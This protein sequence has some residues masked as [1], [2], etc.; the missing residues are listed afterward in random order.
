MW[1]ALAAYLSSV[2]RA[3]GSAAHSLWPGL[4]ERRSLLFSLLLA[5]PLALLLLLGTE[6]GRVL[7]THG[8]VYVTEKLVPELRIETGEI[9]SEHLGGWTFSRLKI[10]YGSEVLLEGRGLEVDISLGGLIGNRIDIEKIGA[11]ELVF[12]DDVLEELLEAQRQ[13]ARDAVEPAEEKAFSPP[14]GRLGSLQ[15]DRLQVIDRRLAGLPAV[16]VRSSG[17]YLWEGEPA[18]IQLEVRELNGAGL[19]LILEGREVENRRYVLEFS[20][21]E[22]PGGFVGT[23]L[24]LPQGQAL[25]AEGHIALWQP[26][27]D[28]LLLHIESFSLPLVQHRFSLS[29]RAALTLSPWKLATEGLQLR[30]DDSRHHIAGTV[31]GEMVDAEIQFNRLPLAISRP[32]QDVLEGGYLSADLKIKGSLKLPAVSGTLD[33]NSHYSGKPLRLQGL[34]QTRDKIIVIDTATVTL[35]DAKLAARGSVDITG[36]SIDLKGEIHRLALDSIRELLAALPQ[37]GEVEIPP[38]LGGSVQRLQLSAKGPWKNPALTAQLDAAL[39]YRQLDAQLRAGA[40]GDLNRVILSEIL[41]DSERLHI[42]GDGTVDIAGESLDLNLKVNTAD[43]RPAEQLGLV[44]AEGVAMDMT[45]QMDVAGP[46]KKPRL[47]ARIRSDGS[48][49]DYRYQLRGGATGDLDK[50]DLDRLRLDLFADSGARRVSAQPLRGPQSLISERSQ[51]GSP[52]PEENP[53]PQQSRVSTLAADAERLSRDGNAWLEVDGTIEPRAARARGRLAGRNIPVSLAELAGVALP[54][55][56]EGEISIDGE[57]SGPF[58]NPEAHAEVLGLG[59]FRGE[60]WQLQGDLAYGGG[61]VAL[62]EVELVW[63]ERNQLSAHGSLDRQRLDLEVRGRAVLADFDEWLAA[64]ITERGEVT[65]SATAAGSPQRPQLE[66]EFK[67]LSQAPGRGESAQSLELVFDWHTEGENLQMTLDARHGARRAIDARARLAVAPI[68][69]QLFADTSPGALKPPLPL[70]LDSSGSADLAVV[71]AFIDPEIH[72]MSGQLRFQLNA[73]GSSERPNMH[74]YV[75]LENGSYEHRPT[76]TRLR[77]IDFAARLTP[78]AW[79]IERARAE[80]TE[81]GSVSLAGAVRFAE[82]VPPVLDFRLHADRAHLLNTPAVRGAISGELALTGD[83]G[84]A[85]LAGVLTLRPLEVQIEQLIG[86]SVP[87]IEVVE[88]DLDLEGSQPERAPSLL[89]NIALAIQVVLDQQSYVRGL[90]L[91]SE[92]RGKVDIVGTAAK[93]RAAG[94]LRIVRGSFDLLGKRFELQEGQV[95]FENNEAAIYVKGVHEYSDGEITAEITGT[96]RDLD[97]TFSSSPAAPQ[98]E[99]F[100]QLLFGKSLSDISPLQ[101]VRLVG[102]VRTLQSGGPTFDPLAKTRDLLGVDTLDIQ[103]EEAAEGEQDQYALSLGKYITNR[104][105]IE[106]QRS[107]DPLNPWQA[108]MEIELR[109]NLSLEIKSAAEGE[110]GAGSVELQW[111][112]DY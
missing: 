11:E 10:H 82:G 72:A 75:D 24:Q 6:W 15:I 70:K 41:L 39:V 100:A 51:P 53:S 17:R 31:S 35:A 48:Y 14:A 67:L 18:G 74:G 56:L 99:I 94:E 102:V 8:T 81:K 101:A 59:A 43:F 73:D 86:S 7:L 22:N 85:Q 42:D 104:I 109:R 40:R 5:L 19:Q 111:K 33:L 49:R 65:L 97:V 50:I 37:T 107:T 89:Q 27:D 106:L 76:S 2:V 29:G 63:A 3:L 71:A 88:V 78:E 62:S 16:S 96:T 25:D 52:K 84:D 83:T 28:Q 77:R 9:G 55:T 108:E 91:D 26:G 38:D 57:F 90:G 20:A 47:S 32:W 34:V 64:D 54:P 45:A 68:L 60:H 1:S 30:V 23:L 95:Q 79:R 13:A 80:D 44:A 87:E 21:K 112:K 66:G 46:W 92:L 93:P 110:S 61:R 98:D 4:G 103:Q 36:E 69:E 105:Y 58:A 12:N